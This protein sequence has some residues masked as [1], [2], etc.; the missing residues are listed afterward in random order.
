MLLNSLLL[1]CH[2]PV[3]WSSNNSCFLLTFWLCLP[4]HSGCMLACCS[5]HIASVKAKIMPT[6]K[7]KGNGHLVQGPHITETVNTGSAEMGGTPVCCLILLVKLG[8]VTHYCFESG[9]LF[10]ESE[11]WVSGKMDR[12]GF[13]PQMLALVITPIYSL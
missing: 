10:C 4:K 8:Q 12:I 11:V 2:D 3:P 9:S 13:K 7:M 6:K 5:N 1:C